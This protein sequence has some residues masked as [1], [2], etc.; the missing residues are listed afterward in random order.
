MIRVCD[1]TDTSLVTNHTHD[2]VI[3]QIH[4]KLK[5]TGWQSSVLDI[6]WNWFYMTV[7]IRNPRFVTVLTYRPVVELPVGPGR[8]P[9]PLLHGQSHLLKVPGVPVHKGRVHGFIFIWTGLLLRGCLT[10][11]PSWLKDIRKV[12]WVDQ[13]RRLKWAHLIWV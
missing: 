13:T 9:T 11:T 1:V 3:T 12:S 5:L 8:L 6:S 7:F 10:Q 2:K 4:I